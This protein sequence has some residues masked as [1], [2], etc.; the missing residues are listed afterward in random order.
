M[1]EDRKDLLTCR[2]MRGEV[3]NENAVALEMALDDLRLY[4]EKAFGAGS[5]LLDDEQTEHK[6]DMDLLIGTA[7]NLP[8][9][10][11]LEADGLIEKIQVPEQGFALDILDNDGE[12]TA[13]LR[14]AD[15]LGLQY[16]VYGFAEQF[17][18]VRFVHP[19]LDFQPET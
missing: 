13:V 12:R 18:G 19:L 3:S 2:V 14:A 15:R 7:G 4:W 9:I 11:A 10:A 1:K 17:L 16:A 5:F 8:A 6:A